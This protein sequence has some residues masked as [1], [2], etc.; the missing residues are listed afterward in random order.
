MFLVIKYL[1]S[2]KTVCFYFWA[3]F[4]SPF[5]KFDVKAS[6]FIKQ[7]VKKNLNF[8]YKINWEFR[9]TIT[10]RNGIFPH[11]CKKKK[12]KSYNSHSVEKNIS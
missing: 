5:F 6:I 3:G 11:N 2:C 1:L 8:A 12:E 9:Q 10:E 4:F 7:A